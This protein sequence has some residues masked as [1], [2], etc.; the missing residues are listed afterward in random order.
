MK[1]VLLVTI[2]ALACGGNAAAATWHVVPGGG[3]DATTIQAGIDL[4]SSGDIVMVAPG[5]YSGLG[6]VNLSFNGKGITLK[7]DSGPLLTVIDCQQTSTGIKFQNGEGFDAMLDGFTIKNGRGYKG[8]AIYISGASPMICYNVIQDCYAFNKGGAFYITNGSPMIFNNTM[9][10]NGAA[11]SGGCFQ[12]DS[13]ASPQIY[14]NIIC[15]TTNAGA[16]SCSSA[17]GATFVSC[18]DIWWN[19]GGDVV[20]IGNTGSNYSQDP[21][22]CGIPGSG[23]YFL[24]QTS[25]CSSSFSPCFSTVGAMAVQCQVTSVQGVTWGQV[26]N[27]YR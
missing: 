26:K 9:D 10:A 11:F 18:N 2:F 16:F 8:G 6:N 1:T 25:P 19:A 13:Q 7:S 27:M 23:N 24:Q 21:M 3:G 17:S 15:H 20:C 5:T 14:Q 4:A 22:F 12:L